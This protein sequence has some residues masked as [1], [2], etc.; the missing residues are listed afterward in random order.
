MP[1]PG[2]PEVYK[3]VITR[4]YNT[5]NKRLR[6]ELRGIQL[7]LEQVNTRLV[8]A[9][10]R[11]IENGLDAADYKAVKEECEK[12]ITQF[13]ARLFAPNNSDTNIE[14]LLGKALENLCHLEQLWEE[15][16]AERKRRIIGSIFPEKLIFDGKT[17]QTARLNEGARLIYTLNE[18]CSEN[19]KGQKTENSALSCSVT[20]I[21]FKPMTC[22][23]EGSCSIQLSYRVDFPHP[24]P[25]RAF[26]SETAAK[27]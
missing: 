24:T 22:C 17:F 20:R 16:T 13:E 8:K 23:L 26:K 27:L 3:E 5:Q 1:K 10:N 14:G 7:E 21:G 12:K 18:G 25:T 15:A 4:L 6:L 19:E 11:I 2:M 9:R